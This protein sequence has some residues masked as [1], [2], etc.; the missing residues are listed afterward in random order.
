MKS[1]RKNSISP[2]EVFCKDFVDISC[3]NASFRILED[4]IWLQLTDFLSKFAL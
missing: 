2:L 4:S 3:E 1:I